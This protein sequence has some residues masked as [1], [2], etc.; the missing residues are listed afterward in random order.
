MTPINLSKDVKE[1]LNFMP[2][3]RTKDKIVNLIIDSLI[4]KLW[5][6]EKKLWN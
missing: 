5:E 3:K 6:C 1:V 2:G 4:F